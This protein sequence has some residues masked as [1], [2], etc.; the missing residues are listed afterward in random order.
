MARITSRGERPRAW[1][2]SRSTYARIRRSF[3]PK[4]A[5]AMTPLMPC[6]QSRGKVSLHHIGG[7]ARIKG[8]D[9]HRRSF[10]GWQNVGRDARDGRD[11][12]DENRQSHD[13]DGVG[14][15]ECGSDHDFLTFT[16]EGRPRLPSPPI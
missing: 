16:L 5:G 14:I 11:A 1:T 4:T 2:F 6:S 3:P 9:L 8:E 12:D 10:E 15:S 7:H 13:D